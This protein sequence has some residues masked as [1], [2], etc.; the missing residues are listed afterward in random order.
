MEQYNA[1]SFEKTVEKPLYAIIALWRFPF[2][3]TSTKFALVLSL[4]LC[5][6]AYENILL[7]G[8]NEKDTFTHY[9]F[10]L[11]AIRFIYN[12]PKYLRTSADIMKCFILSPNTQ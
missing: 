6:I 1:N 3:D 11:V 8:N 2:L 5:K 12:L 10:Y 7:V 4:V 9:L